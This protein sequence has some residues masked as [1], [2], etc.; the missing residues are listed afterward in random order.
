ML[1]SAA[2]RHMHSAMLRR[3]LILRQVSR[4]RLFIRYALMAYAVMRVGAEAAAPAM[5]RQ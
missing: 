4:C 3:L 1:S 5:P 2:C